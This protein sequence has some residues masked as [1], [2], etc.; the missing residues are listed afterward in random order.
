MGNPMALKGRLAAGAGVLVLAASAAG[1]GSAA[2]AGGGTAAAC[3]TTGAAGS[4]LGA[5]YRYVVS[6]GPPE[7]M[8]SPT[9]VSSLHPKTGEVMLG[10]SMSMAAGSDARHLEVHICDR[11]KGN[12]VL[13]A[14]PAITLTDNTAHTVLALPVATMQG[15]TSGAADAHYGNNVAM[16][17]HHRFNISVSFRGEQVA[18]NYTRSQ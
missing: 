14:P 4:M 13:G 5:S 3:A 16:P 12:A 18:M 11:P 10:G 2:A 8:Y 1:C 6:V 15:V 7:Q 9:Q 17:L